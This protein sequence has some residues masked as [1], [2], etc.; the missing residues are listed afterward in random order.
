MILFC[1]LCTWPV[2]PFDSLCGSVALLLFARAAGHVLLAALVAWLMPM[3]QGFVLA[4][5]A[6]VGAVMLV[7]IIM[8]LLVNSN[9]QPPLAPLTFAD[10]FSRP[11][12][13]LVCLGAA[14]VKGAASVADH[15][16]LLPYFQ[17]LLLAP[18]PTNAAS[19]WLMGGLALGSA[20]SAGLPQHVV[21]ATAAAAMA[22]AAA[23]MLGYTWS[24]DA[25]RMGQPWMGGFGLALGVAEVAL[26][27]AAT[28][29]M[30]RHGTNAAAS[31]TQVR[32]D[33]AC[34]AC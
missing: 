34:G 21:P 22:A 11:G 7:C 29:I 27:V 10:L 23:C 17:A 28:A 16:L 24:L 14:V 18:E 20:L 25:D 33:C 26:L 32:C 3:D 6:P 19:V 8:F 30:R 2:Y 1:R 13:P 12:M 9:T 31:T 5:I 15:Y 4:L